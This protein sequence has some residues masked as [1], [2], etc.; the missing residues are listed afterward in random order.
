MYKYI[1]KSIYSEVAYFLGPP[2]KSQSEQRGGRIR[3]EDVGTRA[4][5][6]AK[7]PAKHARTQ[8]SQRAQKRHLYIGNMQSCA[9]LVGAVGRK[10]H[11][12]C[13][14][15]REARP[16]AAAETTSPSVGV[17]SKALTQRGGMSVANLPQIRRPCVIN[18]ENFA[19][20]RPRFH[21]PTIPAY[22][23]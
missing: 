16:A 11:E 13:T 9:R 22:Q 21:G 2:C 8:P 20:R 1:T 6:E 3:P 10:N 15:E 7:M 23:K 14:R 19:L 4:R 12:P 17:R 18:R 5:R